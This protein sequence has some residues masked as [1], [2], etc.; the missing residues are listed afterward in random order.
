[1]LIGR[2]RGASP[3][4]GKAHS[5]QTQ[6]HAKTPPHPPAHGCSFRGE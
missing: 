4:I 1:M 3:V 5:R 6:Q 2:E